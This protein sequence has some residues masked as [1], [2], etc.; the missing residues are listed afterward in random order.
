MTAYV[1]KLSL[2]LLFEISNILSLGWGNN[3]T[4]LWEKKTK[5]FIWPC[6]YTQKNRKKKKSRAKKMVS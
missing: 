2:G 5:K 1:L 3:R 4:H 6:I